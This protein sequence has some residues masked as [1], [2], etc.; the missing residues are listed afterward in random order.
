[1]P[2]EAR[3]A[4]SCAGYDASRRAPFPNVDHQ[5]NRVPAVSP[6]LSR[7][8]A[9]LFQIHLHAASWSAWILEGNGPACENTVDSPLTSHD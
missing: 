6:S 3:V 1:M 2:R 4:R 9:F 5:F 7:P 8:V